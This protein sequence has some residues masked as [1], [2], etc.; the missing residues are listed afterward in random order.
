MAGSPGDG[1]G[2]QIIL[3]L[4]RSRLPARP[5]LHLLIV[6]RVLLFCLD[7][8]RALIYIG[9]LRTVIEWRA[10]LRGESFSICWTVLTN[11]VMIRCLTSG[12]ESVKC[13]KLN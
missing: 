4:C 7:R 13:A 9:C 12:C 6:C 1:D 11:N 3:T 8:E 10:D 2:A 5:A